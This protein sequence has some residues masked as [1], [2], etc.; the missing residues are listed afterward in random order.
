MPH[1][2]GIVLFQKAYTI[3][4]LHMF[5]L[6]PSGLSLK[7]QLPAYPLMLQQLGNFKGRTNTPG[8]SSH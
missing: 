2:K 7:V 5:S 6:A 1:L 3:Y 8:M 4:N